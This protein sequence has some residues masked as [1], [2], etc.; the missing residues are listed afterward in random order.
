MVP[1]PNQPWSAL[2]GLLVSACLLPGCVAATD[3]CDRVDPTTYEV[4]FPEETVSRPHPVGQPRSIFVQLL[5]DQGM[6]CHETFEEA[7]HCDDPSPSPMEFAV[8]DAHCPAGD[9]EVARIGD[10]GGPGF[11]D[12][13]VV[14]ST[15]QAELEGVLS[16]RDDVGAT[17]RYTIVSTP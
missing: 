6:I 14:P 1:S 9:C 3:D 12:I 7:C 2:R 15:A 17:A 13:I 10:Y 11:V 8:V 4:Y 5:V 16:R